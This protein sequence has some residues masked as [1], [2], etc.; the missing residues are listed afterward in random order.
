MEN[1]VKEIPGIIHLLTQSP[2]SIQRETVETYFTPNASFTHPF[3]RTGSWSNSRWLIER[4][5]RWYK[6][7][8]PRIEIDVESVAFDQRHLILYTTISQT[9][10][11]WPVPF[12]AA[13]VR[14]TAVLR[15]QYNRA[16]HKYYIRSQED[17]YQVDQFA[18]FLLP[19][20]WVLVMLWQFVAA[21][22]CVL[23]AVLGTPVSV[24][25]EWYGWGS[26]NDKALEGQRRLGEGK[27]D[28]K[29][30]D[31]GPG[32]GDW[33]EEKVVGEGEAKKKRL[34]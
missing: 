5:Y 22:M 32:V 33:E 13:P 3:C 18:R 11:L 9:F 23:G 30:L 1:P 24:V 4:I 16:D 10:R 21:L 12:Y 7:M 31:G 2:P 19:G 20:L 34:E 28:W 14:L 17:L 26:G 8:S 25:E 27:R 15:L 29:W 6:I